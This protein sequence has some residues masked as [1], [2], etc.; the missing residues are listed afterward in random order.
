VYR[1]GARTRALIFR[2]ATLAVVVAAVNAVHWDHFLLFARP[3]T[4][5][6]NEY[7]IRFWKVL[8]RVADPDATV[9]VGWAGVVPYYSRRGCF[10][11]L[12]RCDRYI[13]HLPA[14]PGIQK[15]GHN[16]FD[17]DYTFN[18]RRPDIVI[19]AHAPELL[20]SYRAFREVIDG[21]PLPFFVRRDS[22]HVRGGEPITA[23]EA[24]RMIE[25]LK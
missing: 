7:N 23:E 9:A 11:I 15:A 24:R 17:F 3:Q 10:D 14:F 6:G 20:P 12:G 25:S 21:Q 19:H 8:D 5:E 16:K 4:T 22:Q 2:F 1:H 13:A 18:V